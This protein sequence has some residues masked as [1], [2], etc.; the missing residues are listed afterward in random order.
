MIADDLFHGCALQLLH[1]NNNLNLKPALTLFA[2]FHPD[3]S[4]GLIS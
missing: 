4:T 3:L 2:S 1:I